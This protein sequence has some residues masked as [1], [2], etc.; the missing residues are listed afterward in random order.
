MSSFR[1]ASSPRI[2]STPAAPQPRGGG[3]TNRAWRTRTRERRET[4]KTTTGSPP[5]TAARF[6]GKSLPRGD[7]DLRQLCHH[8]L[9]RRR[10]THRLVDRRDSPALVDVERP[11]VREAA[12][13][14]QHAVLRRHF[15]G[16]IA[17][18]REIRLLLLD[19]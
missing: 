18:K 3:N 11:A 8:V 2:L 15:L 9:G 13:R 6:I 19:N 12:L 16:R 17:E 14:V 5:T 7:P 4:K 10:R 1:A